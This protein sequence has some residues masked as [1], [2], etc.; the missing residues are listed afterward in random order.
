MPK[1]LVHNM[2]H[3]Q[4]AREVYADGPTEGKQVPL[5]DASLKVGWTKE[6]EHV[7]VAVLSATD[8]ERNARHMQL[9]RAGINRLIRLLRKARDD[10]FGSDA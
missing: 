7:E 9:D 8:D 1:E 4:Y 5:D 2:Y 3:G 10:A 6:R